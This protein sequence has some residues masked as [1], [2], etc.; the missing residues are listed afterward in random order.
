MKYSIID[1]RMRECEK[2]FLQS[3]GYRLIEIP[4][5]EEVYPEIS[6]HVDIFACKINNTIFLEKS[7]FEL[8]LQQIGPSKCHVSARSLKNSVNVIQKT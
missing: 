3:L 7:I 8:V 4:K 5:S 6:S 1:C 2:E